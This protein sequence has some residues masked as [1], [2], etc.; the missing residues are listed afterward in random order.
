M[1]D[2]TGTETNRS[3]ALSAEEILFG[4]A[5][6]DA[7]TAAVEEEDPAGEAA[8]GPEGPD[9]TA[10]QAAPPEELKVVVSI[11]GD[12][13]TIGVQQP[14]ADPHIESFDHLDLDLAGLAPGGPGGDRK[15]ESPVGG[16]TQVPDPRETRSPGPTPDPA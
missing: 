15:G 6:E 2:E 1:P 8:H 4:D 14:S 11:R 16:R 9:D 5:A 3:E 7:A 13:A 12:R 10:E